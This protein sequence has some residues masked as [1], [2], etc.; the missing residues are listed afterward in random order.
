MKADFLLIRESKVIKKF[1]DEKKYDLKKIDKVLYDASTLKI[2]PPIINEFDEVITAMKKCGSECKNFKLL[3]T[4]ISY[5]IG[6]YTIIG[7]V[8]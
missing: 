8:G 2:N 6:D 7:D 5:K 4:G 3:A 1:L